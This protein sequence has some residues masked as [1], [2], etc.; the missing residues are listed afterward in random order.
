MKSQDN[1][2]LISKDLYERIM[3]RIFSYGLCMNYDLLVHTVVELYPRIKDKAEDFSMLACVIG[4][5]LTKGPLP[6]I[7]NYKYIHTL[8]DG[9]LTYLKKNPMPRDKLTPSSILKMEAGLRFLLVRSLLYSRGMFRNKDIESAVILWFTDNP[10]QIQ[11]IVK[12]QPDLDL[13]KEYKEANLIATKYFTDR[14]AEPNANGEEDPGSGALK[15][16]EYV[17]AEG[18]TCSVKEALQILYESLQD[19]ASHLL[20]SFQYDQSSEETTDQ[21]SVERPGS[22]YLTSSNTNASSQSREQ[23]P[24]LSDSSPGKADGGEKAVF[25]YVEANLGE[26]TEDQL[27]DLAEHLHDVMMQSQFFLNMHNF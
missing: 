17:G 14:L 6:N 11:N 10:E 22:L 4:N 19:Q 3:S 26:R 1:T 23:S 24:R 5:L 18:S 15:V 8:H 25:E 16:F 27:I 7:T 21:P 12:D 9:V 2:P 20:D 13:V